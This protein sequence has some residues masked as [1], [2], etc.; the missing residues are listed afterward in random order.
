MEETSGRATEEVSL[1]QDGQ[2]AVKYVIKLQYGQ[3]GWQIYR[4]IANRLDPWGHWA[5]SCV[6]KQMSH[7][8]SSPPWQATRTHKTPNSNTPF[9]H[10]RMIHISL[11]IQSTWLGKD[12][13]Q[14]LCFLENIF[15]KT[16]VVTL[17][18]MASDPQNGDWEHMVLCLGTKGAMNSISQTASGFHT[19]VLGKWRSR[20]GY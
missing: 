9:K 4:E 13:G 14:Q 3:S 7:T 1:S 12:G 6:A 16:N 18:I 17:S 10:V 20:F 5:A 2:Y 8:T 15:G 19:C 11:I